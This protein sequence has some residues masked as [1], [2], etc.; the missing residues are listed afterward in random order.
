MENE[1]L[2]IIG[3]GLIGKQRLDA[4]IEFG[5]KVKNIY[6]FDLNT[7]QASQFGEAKYSDLNIVDSFESALSFG[8]KRAIVAVPHDAAVGM[9]SALL[10]TGCKV[11]LEKPLGRNI[12]EAQH[13]ASH[14]NSI[15]LSVG[16]N[17]RFMPG[18][19]RLKSQLAS[20][21]LGTISSI[22]MELGH[23]GAP[24]DATSWK[25]N[26]VMAGGGVLL[27]PGIHLIDLMIHL[28][29]IDE[30]DFTM[31][32]KTEWRGFWNTGIEESANLLGYLGAIPFVMSSSIVAWRTRFKV[33]VIGTENYFE[34]DGRGRS[35]G[36]QTIT[37]GP[38]WGW[39]SSASQKDSETK[40]E[41]VK[42]DNSLIEETFDWLQEG[43][44]ICNI[45]QALTGMKIYNKIVEQNLVN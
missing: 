10:D 3:L 36:P 2:L 1:N 44:L 18:I 39:L 33:E 32:G 11:I 31:V 30:T 19:I 26:P 28:F 24:A 14:K 37:K 35:D 20:G 25:L 43:K 40:T 21:G 9:V 4:C 8:F 15:N 22:K 34:I 7:E 45:S 41:L 5:I 17:Y 23:G 6:V 38:R 29:E 13:L 42:S 12:T 27:D 16:F